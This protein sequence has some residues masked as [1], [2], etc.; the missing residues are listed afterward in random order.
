MA[1]CEKWYGVK[2]NFDNWEIVSEGSLLNHNY[3]PP[4]TQGFWTKQQRKCKDCNY[5]ETEFK[6]HF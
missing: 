5:L 3:N 4:I 2:H 1:K 6:E